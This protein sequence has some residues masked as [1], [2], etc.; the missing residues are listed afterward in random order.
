MVNRCAPKVSPPKSVMQLAWLF[1]RAVMM[2]RLIAKIFRSGLGSAL[3]KR[4][5]MTNEKRVG[6]TLGPVGSTGR[7]QHCRGHRRIERTQNKPPPP[8]P[9]PPPLVDVQCQAPGLQT[10]GR[11]SGVVS[12]KRCADLRMAAGMV[13]FDD[14]AGASLSKAGVVPGHCAMFASLGVDF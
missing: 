11:Q 10:I 13:R 1:Q 5:S 6:W 8:H 9:I 12:I 7:L 4:G 2:P 3:E 14:E